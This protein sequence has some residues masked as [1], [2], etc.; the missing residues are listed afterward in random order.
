MSDDPARAGSRPQPLRKGEISFAVLIEVT[1]D[2]AR[3][4]AVGDLQP[5]STER[6]ETEAVSQATA[7]RRPGESRRHRPVP[8]APLHGLCDARDQGKPV[9]PARDLLFGNPRP[10]RG[11]QPGD[12]PTVEG[13]GGVGI[14]GPGQLVLMVGEAGRED[15]RTRTRDEGAIDIEE[16]GAR[17]IGRERRPR[18]PPSRGTP[19]RGTPHALPVHAHS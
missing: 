4:P 15:R 8:P 14:L 2:P 12:P 16:H 9:K 13:I 17:V 5:R 18:V 10:A 19:E 3:E 1:S 7:D 11:V 6:V